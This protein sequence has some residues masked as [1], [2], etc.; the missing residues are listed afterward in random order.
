MK[1]KYAMEKHVSRL[2]DKRQRDASIIK[3][4]ESKP[5]SGNVYE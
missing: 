2:E 1:L 5:G 4:M 3:E